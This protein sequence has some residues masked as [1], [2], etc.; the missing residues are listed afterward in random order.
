MLEL[1]QAYGDYRG[2]MDLTEG[3]IVACVDRARRRPDA[4]RTATRP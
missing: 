3:L 4:S 2:M 1:Y